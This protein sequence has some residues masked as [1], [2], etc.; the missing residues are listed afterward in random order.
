MVRS[1]NKQS[2]RVAD[3]ARDVRRKL[4]GNPTALDA[5]AKK[6]DELVAARSRDRPY[7]STVD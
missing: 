6:I 4:A 2:V 3:V 7:S 1:S 5:V